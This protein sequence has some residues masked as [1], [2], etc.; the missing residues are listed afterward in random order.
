MMS[1]TMS[2][3]F[4]GY[5]SLDSIPF[6]R[7]NDFESEDILI[8]VRVK[9]TKK[10]HLLNGR[11][12]FE[13]HDKKFIP[14]VLPRTPEEREQY[15]LLG[16][17]AIIG[18]EYYSFDNETIEEGWNSPKMFPSAK[19]SDTVFDGKIEIF[20]KTEEGVYKTRFAVVDVR[21]IYEY[22]E[23]F[24]YAPNNDGNE[25]LDFENTSEKF[26]RILEWRRKAN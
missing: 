11:Y 8:H 5:N 15:S 20:E 23:S 19:D 1:E 9:A 25:D 24:W 2:E 18:W 13:Y 14:L 7:E 3:R 17:Y 22:D 4:G 12:V 10:E 26:Y 21:F 6:I 16:D